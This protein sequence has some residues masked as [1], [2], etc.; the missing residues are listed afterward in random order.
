[1]RGLQKSRTIPAI[2]E[3]AEKLAKHGVKEL[4]VIAQDS[5]SYGWDLKKKVYLSDLIRELNTIEGID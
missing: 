3:E 5:T 4:I 2:M 1:M